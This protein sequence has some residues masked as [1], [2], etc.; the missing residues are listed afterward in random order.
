MCFVSML[1]TGRVHRYDRKTANRSLRCKSS[2]DVYERHSG[3]WN[4]HHSLCQARYVNTRLGVS[5]RAANASF[6]LSQVSR[7]S[8]VVFPFSIGLICPITI[9][10]EL[11]WEVCQWNTIGYVTLDP[12]DS[13]DLMISL[14]HACMRIIRC[15]LLCLAFSDDNFEC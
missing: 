1:L 13:S 12:C 6:A 4:P 5:V 7:H 10:T 11:W 15:D 9:A 2:F 14:L 3:R 8:S